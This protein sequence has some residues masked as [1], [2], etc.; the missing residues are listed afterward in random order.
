MIGPKHTRSG[1]NAPAS[2]DIPRKISDCVQRTLGGRYIAAHKQGKLWKCADT[3]DNRVAVSTRLE[4]LASQPGVNTYRFRSEAHT[5]AERIYQP[6][7]SN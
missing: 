7:Q 1:F 2:F 4:I 3:D 5:Q 6:R